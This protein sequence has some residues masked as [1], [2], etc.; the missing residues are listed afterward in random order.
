MGPLDDEGGIAL[1]VA[2]LQS[3]LSA[4]DSDLEPFTKDDFAAQLIM[5]LNTPISMLSDCSILSW[6]G[7]NPITRHGSKLFGPPPPPD[8]SLP[9]LAERVSQIHNA[10]CHLQVE[11]GNSLEYISDRLAS[12][13]DVW[14]QSFMDI[15]RH[16]TAL[17]P[18]PAPPLPIPT[19]P[20]PLAPATPPPAP[21]RLRKPKPSAPV[22]SSQKLPTRTPAP[23]SKPTSA[24][25][26]SYS[27]AAKAPARP[28]LVISHRSSTS[29]GGDEPMAVKHQPGLIVAHL[30]AAL[31]ASPHQASISA[32]RWTSKNNLVLT[33]GPDTTAHNLTSSSHF[34]SNV[35]SSLLAADQSAPVPI[36]VRE[37]LRWSRITINNIPT[38]VDHTRAAYTP[39]ECHEALLADNPVYRSLRVTRPPSWVRAP[40]SYQAGSSSSLS[41]A[42]EDPTGQSLRDLLAQRSLFC[43]GNTG[44][45]KRWVEKPRVTPRADDHPPASASRGQTPRPGP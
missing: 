40:S 27:A 12:D 17:P 45:V 13:A 34:L 9:E 30:N 31:R 22:A 3:Q 23:P 6:L 38:G 14:T 42:F 19:P 15:E 11:S 39:Q 43:F 2:S 18:P 41:V 32:A 44:V 36:S 29:D 37:N 26:P 25:V 5:V 16:I 4:E 21:P 33:G 1:I 24:P 8:S 7:I 28:S 35:L 10:I 20:T